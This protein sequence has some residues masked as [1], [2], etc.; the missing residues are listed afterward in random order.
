MSLNSPKRLFPDRAGAVELLAR[1]GV[2][3]D[4]GLPARLAA[5][6]GVPGAEPAVALAALTLALYG[7][8]LRQV[9]HDAH[10]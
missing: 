4:G 3:E 9:P 1:A 2:A 8:Q 10:T 5:A 6:A 7:W